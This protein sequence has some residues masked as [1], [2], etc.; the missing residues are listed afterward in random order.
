MV[1]DEER[2]IIEHELWGFGVYWYGIDE[3]GYVI[4][5][6]TSGEGP[7]P[8][9]CLNYL[10]DYDVFTTYLVD[11]NINNISLYSSQ[12]GLYPYSYA[13]EG[14]YITRAVPVFPSHVSDF[15][16]EYHSLLR[17]VTFSDIRIS[18]MPPI[19]LIAMNI[20]NSWEHRWTPPSIPYRKGVPEKE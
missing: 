8:L 17:T 19:D 18:K 9:V 3:D 14:L 6:F 15:P 13:P 1:T 16:I 12:R 2:Q 4:Q 7:V 10:D 5:F 11:G 20:P